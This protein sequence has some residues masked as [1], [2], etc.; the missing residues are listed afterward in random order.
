MEKA[1]GLLSTVDDAAV[2]VVGVVIEVA[3]AAGFGDPNANVPLPTM[4]D[5]IPSL[6]A[7]PAVAT[8]DPKVKVEVAG[9]VSVVL[10]VVVALEAKEPNVTVGLFC[11]VTEVV[12]PLVGGEILGVTTAAGCP[13]ENPVLFAISV[14][15]LAGEPKLNPLFVVEVTVS[16]LFAASDA[17]GLE[18]KLNPPGLNFT[19][20]AAVGSFFSFVL[21]LSVVSEGAAGLVPKLNP[22]PLVGGT[23][24]G[25][26]LLLP[27]LNLGLSSELVVL[28]VDVTEPKLKPVLDD[29]V[30]LVDE[31]AGTPKE[32][33]V[34]LGPSL[35]SESGGTPKLNFVAE[36]DGLLPKEKEG[37]SSG[38]EPGLACSQ[39]A[40]F[41]REASF[42]VIQALHSHLLADCCATSALK[43]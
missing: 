3:E 26:V 24:A 42:R 22:L 27:K 2:V 9:A 1:N 30:A 38:V 25:I 40:H 18:P 7:I 6:L 5:L 29:V 34:V 41:D 19:V 20:S 12:V 32:K 28:V 10:L 16:E 15:L 23:T 37:A 35:P 33:P 17:P 36:D 13:N 31:L 39:Q 43:P 14:V 21:G 4:I 8:D 11:S